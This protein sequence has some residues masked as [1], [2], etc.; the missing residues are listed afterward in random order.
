MTFDPLSTVTHTVT[1]THREAG[2]LAPVT[3]TGP[4]TP[5]EAAFEQAPPPTNLEPPTHHSLNGSQTWTAALVHVT[6]V[7]VTT[8]HMLKR[9][10]KEKKI[11][12]EWN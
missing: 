11:S 12:C 10:L 8:V 2:P 5:G 3:F 4:R 9:F 7:H 6:T 1:H